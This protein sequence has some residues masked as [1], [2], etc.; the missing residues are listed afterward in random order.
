MNPS[1]RLAFAVMVM[2]IFVF[3][4]SCLVGCST[5]VPVHRSFPEVPEQLM[6]P[7]PALTPLPPNTTELSAL[8]D[9]ANENYHAFRV[10]REHYQAWQQWYTQQ[11]ENFNSVK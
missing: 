10:L 1:D 6:Q 7:A 8:I 11:R 2:I 5:T 4:V 3:V 9:N